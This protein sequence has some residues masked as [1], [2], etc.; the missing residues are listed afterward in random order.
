MVS[1][2]DVLEYLW[3]LAPIQ[4]KED[5]D[6]VGLMVGHRDR[7]VQKLL[8]ALDPFYSVCQEAAD[9]GADLL[10]THHPLFFGGTKCV[11]DETEDGRSALLLIEQGIACIAMHTNLDAAP[12]GVNDCLARRLGLRDIQILQPAGVTENGNVYGI[13]RIGNIDTCSVQDF[14]RAVKEKLGCDGLRYCD[15]GRPVSKVAVGG[16]ACAGFLSLAASLGC[17]AFVTSDCKYNQFQ[18]ARELG[19]SLIDAGHFWTE[20][21]VCDDLARQLQ[22]RFAELEIRTSGNHTDVTKFA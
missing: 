6:Y 15:T 14:A 10:V 18:D 1:V 5:W 20:N 21:V 8:V 22:A 3:E 12:G 17:D 11:T 19:V 4:M 16:G 9:W 13:G 7:P 2:N